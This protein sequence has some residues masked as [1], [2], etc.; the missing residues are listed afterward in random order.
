MTQA[1]E[2]PAFLQ[3][4][5]D[6]QYA[7]QQKAHW[8]QREKELRQAIQTFAFPAD[9][10]LEGTNR[11]ELGGPAKGYKLKFTYQIKR[12][13][14]EASVSP[15]I[16]LLDILKKVDGA[17]QLTPEEQQ[18]IAFLG[19]DIPK[20]FSTDI[21]I[22]NKPELDTKNYKS[23]TDAQRK[24]ADMFVISKEGSHSLELEEPKVPAA[25]ATE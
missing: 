4:I 3:S 23:L 8:E 22:R 11:R 20:P 12:T 9:A 1:I 2:D 6:W 18:A 14:E 15:A 19:N 5:T 24:I 10:R 13:I 16:A 25:P 21:L 7:K 17:Q